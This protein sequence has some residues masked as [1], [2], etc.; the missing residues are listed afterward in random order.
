MKRIGRGISPAENQPNFETKSIPTRA[1]YMATLFVFF[2]GAFYLVWLSIWAVNTTFYEGYPQLGTKL[3]SD[4]LPNG[5]PSPPLSTRY[6]RW[7]WW[8]VYLLA[9]NGLAP[10]LLAMALTHNRVREWAQAHQFVCFWLMILNAV[11]LIILTVF[12]IGHTNN[13]FSGAA[14]AANDYR[15]CCV[16]WPS[17]WC[18]NNAPCT[19]NPAAI[20][21]SADLSRNSEITAHW[22]FSIIFGLLAFW[23][24]KYAQNL[25]RNYGV[26]VNFT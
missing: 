8:A 4:L 10:M 3:P 14:T 19:F 1:F 20:I 21:G 2:T 12:W 7:Y 11:V 5:K 24:I 18:P 25:R 16:F 26:L 6:I 9:W 15:W 13:G 23:N 17:E 22:A